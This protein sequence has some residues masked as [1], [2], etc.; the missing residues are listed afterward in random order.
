MVSLN[1]SNIFSFY[2]INFNLLFFFIDVFF[3]NIFFNI[4]F[5]NKLSFIDILLLIESVN[6]LKYKEFYILFIW[7]LLLS[8]N[9]LFFLLQFF[10]YS[11]YQDLLILYFYYS[12]EL[13]L[14]LTSF[15]YFNWFTYFFNFNKIYVYDFF[16]DKLNVIYLNLIDYF[17]VFFFFF[18]FCIIFFTF[19]KIIKFFI[20]NFYWINIFFY[21]LYSNSK[22]NRFQFDTFILLFFLLVIYWFSLVLTF[23]NSKEDF[24]EWFHLLSFYIFISFI[25]LLVYKYSIHYF[26]FLEVSVDVGHNN[27]FIIKQ[28]FRDSINSFSLLLR[29]FVLLFRLNIYDTLDDFYD[30]Y[31]IFIGDFDDDDYFYELFFPLSFLHFCNI[32]NNDDSNFLFDEE[33]DFFLDYF[34]FYFL[35]WSK[36]FMFFFFIIEELLRLI[37]AFYICYLIIFD[38]HSVN[39]SYNEELYFSIKKK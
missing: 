2:S 7:D 35:I 9:N 30:S 22:E 32:D 27:L 3:K 26:S 31:Y 38:V 13:I 5:I 33:H 17:I 19:F 28:F 24:I 12:P 1:W 10:F 15:I 21:F 23:D 20:F 14:A 18:F 8:L 16:F 39:L 25:V 29:F 6:I 37:L 11:N 4:D 34:Y 36:L